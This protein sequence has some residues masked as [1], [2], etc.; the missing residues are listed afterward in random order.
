MNILYFGYWGARDGLSVATI[1]P[2]LE[3]LAE[4]EFV[5]SIYFVSIEREGQK[6][7]IDLKIKKVRHI[8]LISNRV[9][10]VLLNKIDDFIRFPQKITEFIKQLDISLLICRSS[11]AGILGYLVH[12]KTGVPFWVESFEPHAS[13]MAEAGVWKKWDPRYLIQVVGERLQLKAT[14]IVFPA[15]ENYKRR[16]VTQKRPEALLTIPCT[17]NTDC[18]E[19]NE[20]NREKVR[21]K[22]GIGNDMFC[23][24]YTGKF[25]GLYYDYEAFE[26]FGQAKEVFKNFFLI[27]LTPHPVEE[28]KQKL[29][30]VGLSDGHS[31]V[32]L[33]PHQE[34]PAYMHAAD[35][36]FSTIKSIQSQR[37]SSP[38]KLGE[39]WAAGLPFL[40]TEGV[41]DESEILKNGKGGVLFNI[42]SSREA[43]SRMKELLKGSNKKTYVELAKKYRARG[44]VKEAYEEAFKLNFK[45][46]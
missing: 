11:P 38:I 45:A 13:Y 42:K 8:P 37:F 30:R 16:L 19:F 29:R 46:K 23:G 27:V 28:I 9:S 40:L 33:V 3:I 34:V 35:F 31:F 36:A 20:Q 44:L 4:F 26:M 25:G 32:S 18:F 17:V 24:I 39:Y 41:G 12:K 14:E 1:H 7:P 43:L 15:S 6:E 5:Q 2:H 22:L 10:S 21:N